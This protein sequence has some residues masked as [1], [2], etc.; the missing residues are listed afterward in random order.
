MPNQ[1]ATRYIRG[2]AIIRVKAVYV[3]ELF[4]HFAPRRQILPR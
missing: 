2:K 1:L 3:M 4:S